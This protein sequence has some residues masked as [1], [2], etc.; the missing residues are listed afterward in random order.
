MNT[1]SYNVVADIGGTHAR[2]AL[3]HAEQPEL[4]H[5]RTYFCADYARMED[6]LGAFVRECDLPVQR[7]ALAIATPITGDEVQMTNHHWRFSIARARTELQLDEL[8]VLNDFTA[9]ALS[10]PHI[11]DH[12]LQ[13]IGG[14]VA[15]PHGVI[16]VIGPGTGLGVSGLIWSG[17]TWLPLSGEGGHASFAPRNERE[18]RVAQI[19]S[20]RYGAHPSYE[21]LVSGPGLCA[22]YE[23]LCEIDGVDPQA[24]RPADVARLAAEQHDARLG[25]VFDIFCAAL[26]N[27]AG[28]LALTLGARGG[29][30]IGGGI[31]PRWGEKFAQ[32]GFRAAFESKGRLRDYLRDIPVYVINAQSPALLGVAHL[33]DRRS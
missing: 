9:L 21:R 11:P 18:W 14:S 1:A 3:Q 24:Y 25:E 31:V 4:I 19:L 32:S 15:T 10:L 7:A 23:S 12:Q 33:F 13:Q 30:Y 2:F 8:H 16:G 22:L 6:A 17:D 26:G 29:I 27:A 20:R 28:N 5:P